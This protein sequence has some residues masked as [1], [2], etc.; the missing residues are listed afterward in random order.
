MSTPPKSETPPSIRRVPRQ[1]RSFA[2]M[3]HGKRVAVVKGQD[4]G[5]F[6]DFYHNILTNSWPIFFL[7]LAAAFV[8]V[9][10]VFATLYAVD[11]NGIVNA[12]RATSRTPSSSVSRPWAPWA[13]ARWRRVRFTPTCW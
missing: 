4:S 6:M 11:R 7:K 5:R 13:M 12:R 8:V 3:P 9:N 2:R 1:R 10:L